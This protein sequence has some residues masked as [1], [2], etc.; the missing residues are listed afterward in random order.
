MI[1]YGEWMVHN[2]ERDNS[3]VWVWVGMVMLVG[4]R[5]KELRWGVRMYVK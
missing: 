5:D 2:G 3:V 1:H 4:G